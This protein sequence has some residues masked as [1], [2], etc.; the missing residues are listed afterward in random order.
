MRRSLAVA[1]AAAVVCV[2]AG[3]PLRAQGSAVM[4][5]S[6][7]ALALGGAGVADP[8][9]DGSAILFNPAGLAQTPS[10]ITVGWTGVTAGGDFTYDNTGE[11]IEREEG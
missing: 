9:D 4:T 7:C 8:C 3:T 6:S 2:A 1:S 5:H 11:R 10:L